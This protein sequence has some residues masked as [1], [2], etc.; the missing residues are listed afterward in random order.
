MGNHFK[1]RT[2]STYANVPWVHEAEPQI[3]YINPTDAEKRGIANG[4]LVYVFNARGRIRIAARVT[5]RI[6]P[7]V[8][9]VPQGAWYTPDSNG[10]DVG[11]CANTLTTQ[12]PTPL[13][14][15]NGQY[16]MLAQ[17]EKV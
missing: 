10:V 6:A 7:G 15:G 1:G 14:K 16:T 11:G 9:S 4:D 2:H 5:P 17:V 3:V 13:A 12:M 8:I